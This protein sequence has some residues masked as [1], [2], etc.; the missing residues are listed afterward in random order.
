MP[1][2]VATSVTYQP[3]LGVPTSLVVT[4]NEDVDP[5]TFSGADVTFVGTD[6]TVRHTS[7]VRPVNALNRQ[8]LVPVAAIPLGD[9][10]L[11]IG[12]NVAIAR[13]RRSTG[14]GA[15]E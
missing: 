12:P 9:Y 4:F 7:A 3:K 5:A 11:K 8:F 6:G 10:T 14:I 13:R 15:A 2:V 1:R